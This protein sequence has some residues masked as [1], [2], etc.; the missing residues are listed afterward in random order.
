MTWPIPMLPFHQFKPYATKMKMK[1]GKLTT[2]PADPINPNIKTQ[3]SIKDY[4]DISCY[5]AVERGNNML[6]SI[7]EEDTNH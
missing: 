5:H 6:D 3:S 4:V 7:L 1:K 2:S